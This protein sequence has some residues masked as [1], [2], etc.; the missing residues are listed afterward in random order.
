MI[1][2]AEIRTAARREGFILRRRGG[3]YWLEPRRTR[4]IPHRPCTLGMVDGA[5]SLTLP[6]LAEV[7]P[8]FLAELERRG[9]E[10]FLAMPD[11]LDP[12][13]DGLPQEEPK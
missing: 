5:P 10:E 11:W 9:R 1:T 13:T 12:R 7:L 2:E 4:G 8:A 6:R 3:R